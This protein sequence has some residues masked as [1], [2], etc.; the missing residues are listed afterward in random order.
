[1][2]QPAMNRPLPQSGS[3]PPATEQGLLGWLR[4]NLLNTWF[5]ALLT[6]ISLLLIYRL[7]GGIV[8]WVLTKAKWDVIDVNLRNFMVGSYPAEQ[9][10]RVWAVIALI[11]LLTGLS[12]AAY[13]R[14]RRASAITVGVAVLAL[15]LLPIQPVSRIWL[16]VVLALIF[17]GYALAATRGQAIRKW[18]VL[19]WAVFPWIAFTLIRGTVIGT[20]LPI[21]GTTHWNGLLL[22]V[23]LAAMGIVLCFP[24][25]VMLA[26]GRQSALPVVRLVCVAY[27]ELI[28]AVPLVVWL[29]MGSL[30]VPLFLPE[31]MRPDNII[32]AL[33]VITLFSAA[34]M[35]ENVRGGLQAVPRGQMEAATA[36]GLP[37]WQVALFI[38]LPQALRMVIPAMVGQFIGLLKDTTL[39]AIVS[40]NELYGIGTATL[41]QPFFRD[42]Y[43][44][45]FVFIGL[46]FFIL[47]YSLATASRHL[48]KVLG[49]GER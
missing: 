39:V 31:G 42:R 44:E 8:G 33:I 18:V 37:G 6:V 34:Y 45:V 36:L 30:M 2:A 27:I 28:R 1:M 13:G 20:F 4:K 29:F 19:A 35:A 7:G 9:L 40:L 21:V 41:A 23:M 24:L 16:G 3:R 10:W 49:V 47:C 25:G 14:L 32:R 22:T 38:R 15:Q 11:S 46:L 17:G 48:E 5:N 12:W 26:L 43:F